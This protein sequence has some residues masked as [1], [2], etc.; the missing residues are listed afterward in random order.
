M[1]QNA[2]IA[3]IIVAVV[4]VVLAVAWYMGK[5]EQVKKIVRALVIEAE[6][7]YATGT[8][9]IKYEVVVGQ[10]EKLLPPPLGLI[11]T[12]RFI[13]G[14]IKDA[15]EYIKTKTLPDGKTIEQTLTPEKI[16]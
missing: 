8:G 16:E 15:V 6:R 14:L 9:D 2:I 11:F 1:S 10:I 3:I 4:I 7:N 13:D 12:P 5:K